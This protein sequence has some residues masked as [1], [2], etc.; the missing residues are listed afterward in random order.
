MAS[1]YPEM[2]QI[3]TRLD[4]NVRSV[5]DLRGKRISIDEIGSGTLSVM[6]IVLA[7]YGLSEEDLQPVYLKPEFTH[8]KIRSG[9]LLGFV[10]MGG[11]PVE[12]VTR[13][14][15][16]GLALAPID[17]QT[18]MRINAQFPYLAPG[19][20]PAGVYSG[21]SAT[22]TIQVYALLVVSSTLP[23]ELVYRL[24]QILWSPRMRK[25]LQ[26]GHPQGASITLASALK[27]IP[28]PLHAGAEN[29]Y[30]E[31]GMAAPSAGA[32]AP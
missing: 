5:P 14:M 11:T 20:I 31:Q 16:I 26:S 1:L 25:L 8:E 19:E 24:T 22:P 4:A 6:R 2:F 15:D 10:I 21:V 12:A 13:V 28:I 32:T 30:R 9:E 27:G 17:H 3:V 29:F 18:A 23:D 7:A